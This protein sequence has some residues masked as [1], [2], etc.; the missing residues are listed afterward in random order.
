MLPSNDCPS[1]TIE[2]HVEEA[3][4]HSM[5]SQTRSLH[6]QQTFHSPYYGTAVFAIEFQRSIAFR[7]VKML[8][9][10]VSGW[11]VPLEPVLVSVA[12]PHLYRTNPT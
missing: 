10:C 5:Q 12:K 11:L 8:R 6:N 2:S 7:S 9:L 4:A 3:S 1:Y